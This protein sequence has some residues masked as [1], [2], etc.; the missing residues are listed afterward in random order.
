MQSNKNRRKQRLILLS[1]A[2]SIVLTVIKFFAYYITASNA[3][4]S[5]ALESIIN[6]IGSGFAFYSIRL[7]AQPKDHNHPYG[8]G[9]IEFFS[10]GFEGAL[11]SIAAIF[12]GYGAIVR[13]LNPVELEALGTGSVLIVATLV[14]NLLLGQFLVREGKQLNSMA[15]EADGKHLLSDSLSSGLLL[16]SLLLVWASGE[17]WIDSVASLVFAGV[18]GYNGIRIVRG[19]AARLM[20]EQDAEVVEALLTTL[21]NNRKPYWVDVHNLRVQQ[22]GPDLHLDC[23]LTWPFYWDLKKVHEHV[24]EFERILKAD[25]EGEMEIF[26]HSDP[27]LPACCPF[28]PLTNCP[29]RAHAFEQLIP[30]KLANVS[31]NQKLHTNQHLGSL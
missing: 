16:L 3:V 28:C 25:Y 19:A 26:V 2:V 6:V 23:H 14:V 4:L 31:Q 22:Y 10:A 8:H 9:K 13:L 5:D 7:A 15:L 27:C 20:D 21:N 12:I 29:E 11:I 18:I 24:G 30:W 1:F 17:V